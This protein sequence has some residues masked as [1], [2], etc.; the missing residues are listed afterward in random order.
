MGTDSETAKRYLLKKYL[1]IDPD[2]V[3]LHLKL[4]LEPPA[5]PI[6]DAGRTSR[7]PFDF[8]LF[9]RARIYYQTQRAFHAGYHPAKNAVALPWFDYNGELVA[10]KYRSVEGKS[11]VCADG[12][13]K[14]HHHIF[15]YPQSL[16]ARVLYV[17]EAE[18][19]AMYMVE[20]GFNAV[21]L[22]TAHMSDEQRDL[23]IRHPAH[24]IIIATDNDAAGHK[25][26]AR[27]TK[28]LTGYKNVGRVIFP[29]WRKGY[30]RYPAPRFPNVHPPDFEHGGT[31]MSKKDLILYYAKYMLEHGVFTEDE[32]R[33]RLR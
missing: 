19:D 7:P 23:L 8:R 20:N 28:A 4:E 5:Y 3:S 31:E 27:M 1:A 2:T 9:E 14:V 32:Y 30:E 21:A 17:T 12:G 13:Q 22:G 24:T 11:F 33:G 15:G 26:A 18:I 10:V 6:L 16:G 25:C 29:G